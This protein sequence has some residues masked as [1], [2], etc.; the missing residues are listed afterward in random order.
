MENHKCECGR[1]WQITKHKLT[2]R[3]SDS[4]NCKCGRE[5][6]SWNGAV[7]YTVTLVKDLQNQRGE[8]HHD[9]S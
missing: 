6:I 1:E 5:L 9:V 3:D 7:T 2:A 8:N 4:E